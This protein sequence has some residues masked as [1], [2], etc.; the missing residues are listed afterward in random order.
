MQF[1]RFF[2]TTWYGLQCC[3]SI[4][5]CILI[6]LRIPTISPLSHLVEE[7]SFG[8][9]LLRTIRFVVLCYSL[10]FR[11]TRTAIYNLRH[12]FGL[13]IFKTTNIMN[14]HQNIIRRKSTQKI[15]LFEYNLIIAIINGIGFL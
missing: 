3:W 5:I 11:K 14:N 9:L 6:H 1:T 10:V 15:E 13:A 12:Y 8:Q 4:A 2:V 7:I